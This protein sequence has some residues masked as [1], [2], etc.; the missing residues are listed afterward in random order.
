MFTLFNEFTDSSRTGVPQIILAVW[1]DTYEFATRVEWLGIGVQGNQKSAPDWTSGELEI[2]FK[3][4]LGHNDDAVR[5]REKAYIL[6]EL[7]RKDPGRIAAARE[8]ARLARN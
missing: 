2:A 6:G 4:V 5:I 1:G 7:S 3:S 8:V